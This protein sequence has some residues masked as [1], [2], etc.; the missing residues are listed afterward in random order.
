MTRSTSAALTLPMLL[1]VAACSE[2]PA[3]DESTN[4]S[5]ESST[6]DVALTTAP[7]VAFNYAYRFG[8]EATKIAELQERHAAACE[9]LGTSRCRITGLA[10]SR[11]GEDR[12]QG[13]LELALAPELARKFGKDAIAAVEAAKGN[14]ASI[15][16]EGVDQAPVLERSAIDSATAR[17]GREKLEAE[18]ASSG[19]SES[20]RIDI[21]QQIDA[22]RIAERDAAARGDDAKRA[23][24]RTPMRFTY[25]TEGFLPGISIDRT[26]WA[27]LAFA[28]TLLNALL[29]L[30]IVL[31]VLA[32][33]LGIILLGFVHGRRIAEHLWAWLAP[34]P[35]PEAS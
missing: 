20:R 22:Q 24:A 21:R 14:V 30:V 8:L 28:G 31:A 6:P 11:H 4:M 7:G 29:A 10:F 19:V 2:K 17:A 12:A 1:A 35:A 16:I 27:A 34:R 18:A 26:T 23:L 9:T 25:S 3:H 15:E 32:I 13:V 33:P 5:V